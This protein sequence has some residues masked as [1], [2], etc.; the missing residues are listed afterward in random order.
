MVVSVVSHMIDLL[1][2]QPCWKWQWVM[3]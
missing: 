1:E 2:N 3:L